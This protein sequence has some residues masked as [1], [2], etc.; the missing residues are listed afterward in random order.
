MPKLKLLI[1]DAGVVI[2]LHE[3]K[4]WTAVIDKFEV[5]LSSIV[6]HRESKYHQAKEDE[7]GE[8]IDF[9]H[10]IA[11]GKITVFEVPE[12]EILSFKSQFDANYF[13]DLDDGEAE[14]LAMLVSVKEDCRISSGDAIVYKILGNLNLGEQGISLEEILQQC[15][16]SR[17]MEGFQY[18][19]AFRQQMTQVGAN[20]MIQGRGRKP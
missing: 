6:A 18:G 5:H 16:L 9:A 2:K 12:Q 10:D 14:S 4:L 15:G 19:K 3:M 17:K 8:D 1:L 20:D 11:P 13:A 7:W